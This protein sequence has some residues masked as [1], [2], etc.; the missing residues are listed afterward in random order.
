[1]SNYKYDVYLAGPF[2]NDQQKSKMDKAK[3]ILTKG[4]LTVADPR[5]LGPVIVDTQASAK[6]P[7]F[8]ASIFEGNI[9]GMNDSYAIVACLDEKDIGTA[10][11]LGFFYAAS[12]SG[13]R[14]PIMS[15]SAEVGK[16]NVML[17]QSVDCHFSNY[18]QMEHFFYREEAHRFMTNR[19][20]KFYSLM[21]DFK[22]KMET[23]E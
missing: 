2:F 1:M 16:T 4:G 3:E 20:Q 15:F 12:A 13:P 19:L 17:S 22:H 18:Q 10:F 8:F 23:D 14:R 11:E 7:E 6:T 5:E 9:N 21:A